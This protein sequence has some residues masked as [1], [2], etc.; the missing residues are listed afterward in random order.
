MGKIA[1]GWQAGRDLQ[2]ELIWIGESAW[3]KIR[4]CI[5]EWHE[6]SAGGV[7][8]KQ[9]KRERLAWIVAGLFAVVAMVVTKRC[10]RKAFTPGLAQTP[11]KVSVVSRVFGSKGMVQSEISQKL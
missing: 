5:G 1:S 9:R 2:W 8:G 3:P 7:I 11:Y 6:S 10:H 4:N